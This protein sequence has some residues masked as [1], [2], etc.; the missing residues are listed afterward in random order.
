[1]KRGIT[2]FAIMCCF[3]YAVCQSRWQ[4]DSL[5]YMA[6]YK[7]IINDSINKDKLIVVADSIVDLDRYWV[8]GLEQFPEEQKKLIQYKEK[9]M[10]R[11]FTTSTFCSPL[12]A[13]LFRE[14]DVNGS[15]TILFFSEIADLI[16]RADINFY[17]KKIIGEYDKFNYEAYLWG[18]SYEYLFIFNQD[19]TL[20]K[21]LRRKMILN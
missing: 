18:I 19:G 8:T 2:V 15:N 13:C 10:K 6:A 14:Q 9:Q 11:I 12:L 3:Q 4:K 20:R 17:D 5:M 16:L 1:M 7:Y 21:A